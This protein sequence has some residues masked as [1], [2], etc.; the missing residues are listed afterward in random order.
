VNYATWSLRNL[1]NGYLD[2]PETTI[3]EQGGTAEAVWSNGSVEDGGI[4]LGKFSGDLTNLEAWNFA[5]VSK[6]DAQ[7][8]IEANFAPQARMD[9]TQSTLEDAFQVLN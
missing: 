7:S 4:V 1:G 2:G 5:E 8:F 9:G 3:I 6:D